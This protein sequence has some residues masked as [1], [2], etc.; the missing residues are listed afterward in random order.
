MKKFVI[1][2]VGMIACC[3]ARGATILPPSCRPF[4]LQSI[5]KS[6]QLLTEGSC[7]SGYKLVGSVMSCMQSVSHGCYMYAP[8]NTE[9]SDDTGTFEFVGDGCPLE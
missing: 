5:V 9:F 1:F 2:I 6:D 7:P 8:S 3:G 4:G